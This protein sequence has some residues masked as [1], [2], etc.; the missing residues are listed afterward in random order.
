MVIVYLW[1]GLFGLTIIALL[2]VVLALLV[3][4]RAELSELR[5][6]VR[7][8]IPPARRAMIEGS[9]L[10]VLRGAGEAE[11]GVAFFISPTTALTVAHNLLSA[12]GSRRSHLQRV[13]CARPSDGARFTFDVAALD[14][15]LDFAV[16]RLHVGAPS[17]HFLTVSRN[18]GVA[19]GEKGVFLVTCNIRMAAEAPDAAS[20]GVAWH[21]ARVVRFHPHNF[22][23]DSPA[24][25]GDS[26]GAIVVARTG[27]VIGLHKELVNSA[28]EL[29][30]HKATVG[31]RLSRAAASVQSLI[32]GSSFGCVGVRLDSGIARGLLGAAL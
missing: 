17:V 14:A 31:G 28:R 11:A 2:I 24:F 8:D 12:P 27:E 19:A 30:D 23:Y 5:D 22:L 3:R 20:I 7:Y 21:H 9:I 26:G 13:A 29:F 1:F 25:D 32:K 16:L 15:D 18:I 10:A 4:Q 6:E